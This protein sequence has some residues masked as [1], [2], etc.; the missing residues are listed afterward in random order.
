MSKAVGAITLRHDFPLADVRVIAPVKR[1]D[2]LVINI[3]LVNRTYAELVM[4]ALTTLDPDRIEIVV[5]CKKIRTKV[6]V[7]TEPISYHTTK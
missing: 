2:P 1:G 4:S 7:N 3:D 5:G 6:R